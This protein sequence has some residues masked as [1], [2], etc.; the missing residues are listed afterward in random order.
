MPPPQAP[1]SSTATQPNPS[2]QGQP[3]RQLQLQ[4]RDLQQQGQLSSQPQQQ[5]QPP[6]TSG[7]PGVPGP[8]LPGQQVQ[9]YSI[10]GILH[11]LQFEWQRF[12]AERQQWSVERA[13]LQAR[14]ALL[15][16]ESCVILI[17][18]YIFNTWSRYF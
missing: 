15:Q 4:N 5:Q 10:P 3:Q 12:E 2:L 17:F 11:F 14:I 16:G 18:V 1:D 8:P 9:Q 7:Q 13:E 6:I